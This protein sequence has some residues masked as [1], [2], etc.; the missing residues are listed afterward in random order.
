MTASPQGPATDLTFSVV[1]PTIDRPASLRDSLRSLVAQRFPKNRF[2]VIVVDDGGKLPAKA[3]AAEFRDML[4][5]TVIEQDRAG[6]A[7]ARNAGAGIGRAPYLA[8]IDDDCRAD[9]GWLCEMELGFAKATSNSLLGG[10]VL[11]SAPE[12]VFAAVGQAFVSTVREV[13][14]PAPGGLYF[15]PAA[16][17]SIA[18]N[19]FLTMRGFNAEFRTAE[20]REFC[21]RW[22]RRGGSLLYLPSAKVFHLDQQTFCGFCRK[23]F[24]Y[25]KGAYNFHRARRRREPGQ[26]HRQFFRYYSHVLRSIFKPRQATTALKFLLFL[27]RQ[28]CYTAGYLFE[29]PVR[30]LSRKSAGSQR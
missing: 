9:P 21:D 7:A 26:F 29:G 8:F 24:A 25:G 2:E 17:L 14:Q 22:L 20:D 4:T 19:E 10:A 15:F 1:I 11:N 18:R 12:S 6:P 13:Y 3:V 23:H 30:L 16:N 5:I 28:I 27:A